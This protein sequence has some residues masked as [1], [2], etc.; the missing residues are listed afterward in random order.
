MLERDNDNETKETVFKTFLKSKGLYYTFER[1][2]IFH[3]IIEVTEALTHFSID[4]TYKRLK[5]KGERVSKGTL[6]KTLQLIEDCSII[7][8]TDI[9]SGQ[10]TYE[11]IKQYDAGHL[12]CLRCGKIIEMNEKAITDLIINICKKLNFTI[13]THTFEIKGLCFDCLTTAASD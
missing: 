4:S 12:V 6:Y 7:K 9:S 2:L 11:K 10:C 13:K 3:E 5:A 1:R 8:K